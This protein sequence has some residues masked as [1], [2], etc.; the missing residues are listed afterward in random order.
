MNTDTEA[1]YWKMNGAGNEIVV[2]DLRAVPGRIDADGARALA[3]DE[4]YDQLMVIHAAQSPGTDARIVIFNR[5]GSTAGAC[6]NGMRCVTRVLKEA[7]GN[8]AFQ[9]ETDAG[10]LAC[11]ASDLA[12]IAVDMG[13]P[14]F[15][16]QDIPLAEPFEDTRYIELQIGP[17][18]APILHSPSVASMGNP[19]A[20][21]WVDD[22]DAVDLARVGPMLEHHPI[23]P[24]QANITIAK[25]KSPERIVMR[26]WERGVGLT[27]ACGS[28]AC[29]TAVSAARTGR[30]GRRVETQ[31]P[32]GSLMIHWR[33]SDDHVIM[34][35]P[36]K[37][38]HSGTLAL[39]GATNG[40]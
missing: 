36:A 7:T 13:P 11:N 22:L 10:V 21:F 34:I 5:D 28:A 2:L 20:V 29:A 25:V 39:S 23:F 15:A 3:D 1:R 9:L 19:H 8:D 33:E 35:G 37:H 12:H 24:E 17:I 27:K 38:E 18:D 16:W 32:G 14:K 30:T 31:L 26:T 4:P 6:G 40:R